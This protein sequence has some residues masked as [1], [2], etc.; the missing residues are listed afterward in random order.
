MKYSIVSC[1]L[2][3]V[4]AIYGVSIFYNNNPHLDAQWEIHLG[5]KKLGEIAYIEFPVKNLGRKELEIFDIKSDC[6]CSSL[7][8]LTPKGMEPVS[9]VLVPPKTTIKLAMRIAVR[10][11]HSKKRHT[12][13]SFLQ[14]TLSANKV[15][16]FLLLTKLGIFK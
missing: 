9:K 1:C 16:F 4:L 11:G 8:A 7:E 3:F 10:G 13:F 2:I 12:E 6:S 5:T 14:M 15:V